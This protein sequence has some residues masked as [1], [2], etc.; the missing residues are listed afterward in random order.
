M[1]PPTCGQCG[2]ELSGI[3]ARGLCP[4]CGQA[5]DVDTGQGTSAR[6]QPWGVRHARTIGL[7]GL[8]FLITVCSGLASLIAGNPLA[9]L[10]TGLLFAGLVAAGALLSYLSEQAERRQSER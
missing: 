3:A 9:V 1:Q 5:Y 8:A 7:V 4:E 6:R 10:L 2:Y